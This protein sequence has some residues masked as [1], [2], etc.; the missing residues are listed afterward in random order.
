MHISSATWKWL[1]I[2]TGLALLLMMLAYPMGYDQAVFMVGGEMTLKHG[3]IPYRDFIDTKPPII[4]LI[5][6]ISSLIFGHQEWSIRA[7]DILF[8]IGSLCYFYKLLKRTTGDE[9]LALGSAFLYVL[10]Y[11]T[12][13]YWMTA[14]AET[15]ALLPSLLVFD[16]TDRVTN[17]TA[18]HKTSDIV[19]GIYAGLA[20]TF[21]F[22]LKFTLLTIPLGVFIYLLLSSKEGR[23]FPWKY[24]GGTILGFLAAT[25]A[26]LLYLIGTDALPRFLESLAWLKQYG[27]VDPLFSMNTIIERYFK[28][29]PML[30]I[31]PYGLSGILLA[32]IGIL[33][34]FKDRLR[35]VA[36]E[37]GNKDTAL[38]H[39][40]IQLSLG[41]LAVLYER[42]FF[43]Y[44][45]AR[46]YWAFVP[47]VVLGLRELQKIWKDYSLSWMRLK[48]S[49]KILRCVAY[50]FVI[51]FLIFFSTAPRIISQPLH[52]LVLGLTGADR[53]SDVQEKK[54]QYFYKEE[55]D[56]AEHF[57]PILKPDDEV[58]VWGNSIGIYFFLGRRPRTLCLTNTPFITS[59]TPQ[60]WKSTLIA[61]LRARPPKYF[62]VESGDERE[63]I[64]GSAADS[65][66]HLLAW[67][68][69]REF[70]QSNYKQDTE[71]GH[72]RI[73]QHK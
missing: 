46:T 41:L 62:I 66:Q 58:F 39:L 40:F 18:L 31:Y 69:L 26:Y 63:Y 52:F 57:R 32:A 6:G 7:F 36:E 11:V 8:Q 60:A 22:L 1:L 71:I 27:D 16:L 2:G 48:R 72:F 61:Q 67:V 19:P 29:F 42:K 45:F 17:R 9:K 34:Y 35:P 68:D 28:L 23:K 10:F 54:P 50:G 5:Y 53:A 13:G 33:W 38:V 15:F 30:A 70:L 20:Y 73:F 59:W 14:Q 44:H 24:V 56:I 37:E 12:S 64:S 47:F 65:W 3:A 49:A 55:Q 51:F 25:G 43:P 21:L 4:F